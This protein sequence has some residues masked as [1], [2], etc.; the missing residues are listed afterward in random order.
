MSGPDSKRSFIHKP[1][2][3]QAIILVSGIVFN[4][5]LAWMLIIFVTT[6]GAPYSQLGEI[7]KGS[8]VLEEPQTTI[9]YVEP[10]FPANKAGLLAGDKIIALQVG[11]DKIADN[12]T[13]EQVQQFIQKIARRKFF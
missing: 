11:D 5:L 12:L 4:L 3:A 1:K 13:V 10:N 6:I 2:W 7:P 9:I 8:V